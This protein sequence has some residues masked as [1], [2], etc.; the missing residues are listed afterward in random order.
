MTHQNQTLIEKDRNYVTEINFYH[1]DENDQKRVAAVVTEAAQILT[2][3]VGFIAANV[4][5]SNDRSRIC[6]YLQWSD[7]QSLSAAQQSVAHLWT[8]DFEALLENESGK[9]RLYEV[10]YTDDRSDIGV[11]VIS[12]QYK[13]TV[14]INEIT[15]IPGAKQHRLLELVIDNNVN[16]SFNTPGYRSANFHRSLDGFRAVNYSL[17]DT[18]EHLIEAISEMADQDVN[19]EETIELATPDFRFYTLTFANHI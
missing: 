11:S 1:M 4:L 8:A 17:W 10:F 5:L 16:Q 12:K 9:P 13:N 15:T 7:A 2:Q 3:Q 19:L 18:E 14:F 6:T